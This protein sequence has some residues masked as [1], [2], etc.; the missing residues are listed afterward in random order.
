MKN[1]KPQKKIHTQA[2]TRTVCI[3][4]HEFIINMDGYVETAEFG[5]LGHIT[6]CQDFASMIYDLIEIFESPSEI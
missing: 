3:H 6:D 5:N 2:L 4:G 1:I